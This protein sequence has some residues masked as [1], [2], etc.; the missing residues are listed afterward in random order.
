VS[1]RRALR[2][3]PYTTAESGKQDAAA[4]RAGLTS[5]VGGTQAKV[6]GWYDNE[7]GYSSRLAELVMR[8]N[9]VDGRCGCS[10]AS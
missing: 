4:P 8:E 2:D 10:T 7:R 1:P 3:K 6:V 9:E 5:V